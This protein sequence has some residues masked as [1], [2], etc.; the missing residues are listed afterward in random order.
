MKKTLLAALIGCI[1]VSASAQ[2]FATNYNIVSASYENFMTSGKG[3]LNEIIPGMNG[4]GIEYTHGLGLSKTLPLYLEAGLKFSM[5]NGSKT[6][7]DEYEDVIKSKM[8]ATRLTI[9]VSLSYIFPINDDIAIMPYAGVDLRYYTSFK[10]KIE[11]QYDGVSAESGWI[12]LFGKEMEEDFG[13]KGTRFQAGWHIGVRGECKGWILGVGFGT[14]F[15][16]ILDTDIEG[17]KTS[18]SCGSLSVSLGYIF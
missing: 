16:K 15:T 8:K 14:E 12:S 11:L 3:D 2:N 17:E 13:K 1:A 6:Y 10:S 4:F 18:L 7:T 9:P 5:A